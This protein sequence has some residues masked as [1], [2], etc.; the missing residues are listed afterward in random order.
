M[1]VDNGGAPVLVVGGDVELELHVLVLHPRESL[2][3][4]TSMIPTILANQRHD[5]SGMYSTKD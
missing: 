2:S 3:L 4:N 1:V 5:Q